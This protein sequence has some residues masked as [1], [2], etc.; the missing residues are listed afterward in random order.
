MAFFVV[1]SVLFK[2]VREI[3]RLEKNYCGKRAREFRDR[4][5]GLVEPVVRFSIIFSDSIEARKDLKSA[6]PGDCHE[7]LFRPRR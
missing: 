2:N 6:G 1:R 7:G 4:P 5:I 3:F